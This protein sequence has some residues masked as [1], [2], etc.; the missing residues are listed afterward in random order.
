VSSQRIALSLVIP[1][2]NEAKRLPPYLHSVR[3]HLA[4]RYAGS[5]EV[6]VVD[7]GSSDGLE[8]I[9]QGFAA[10]WPQLRFV[11]HQRNQGKGAAVRTGVLAAQGELILFADADGATPIDEEARLAEAIHA[12]AELAIG[13]R[14]LPAEGLAR[15]RTRLRGLAGRCF[16]ALARRLL[17]LPVQDTQCGFKMFRRDAAHRLFGLVRES[18]YLFDLEVLAL[19]QRLGYRIAEVPVRWSEIPGGHL[20]M[21]RHLGSILAALWRVHRRVKQSVGPEAPFCDQADRTL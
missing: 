20:S 12:G 9:L 1:A 5:H 15:S 4:S 16:A 6:I 11:R 14:L 3:T 13:S 10:D 8:E 2:Y 7:D 21:T 18:G 17:R 19:A